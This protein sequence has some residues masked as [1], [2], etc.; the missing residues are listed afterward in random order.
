MIDAPICDRHP[1]I[2]SLSA[3][4]PAVQRKF[5]TL[6]WLKSRHFLKK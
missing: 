6:F 2:I 1:N 5:V 4:R 3:R